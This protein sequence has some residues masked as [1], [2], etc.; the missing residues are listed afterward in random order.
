[1]GQDETE[2]HLP[3]PGIDTAR[4]KLSGDGGVGRRRLGI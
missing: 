4:K 3:A 1:M 2:R